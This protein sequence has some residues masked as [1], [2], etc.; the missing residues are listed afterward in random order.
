[1]S[2]CPSSPIFD[3]FDQLGPAAADIG[4]DPATLLG[5]LG[6]VADPRKRRGVRHR[7]AAVLAV[8]VCAVLTGAKTFI[9]IAEWAHGLPPT[10]RSR[11]GFTRAVP[12]E[13]T[14]RRVIQATDAD[15]LDAVV[16]AWLAARRSVRRSRP[17][18][19]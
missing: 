8:G 7:V 17:A 15:D 9:A 12:S 2:A 3:A 13:S 14:I 19:G 11:L 18:G 5:A 10:V 1:M 4:V 6:K 16:S